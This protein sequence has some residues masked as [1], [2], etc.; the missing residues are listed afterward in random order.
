[1]TEQEKQAVKTLNEVIDGQ[2]AQN[3]KLMRLNEAIMRAI[4]ERGSLTKQQYQEL[5]AQV[6]GSPPPN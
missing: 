4:Y 1:M 2:R 6:C 5:Y 3:V